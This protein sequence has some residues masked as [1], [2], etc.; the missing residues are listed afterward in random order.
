MQ[1]L[2][3]NINGIHCKNVKFSHTRYYVWPGADP[4]VGS[5]PADDF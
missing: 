1:K 4:G 3:F 2:R 5:Q